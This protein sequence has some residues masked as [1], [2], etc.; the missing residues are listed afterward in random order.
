[1]HWAALAALPSLTSLIGWRL[2]H[3]PKTAEAAVGAAAPACSNLQHLGLQGDAHLPWAA[4]T[5][6]TGLTSL[7][8]TSLGAPDPGAET[9]TSSCSSHGLPLPQLQE[10]SLCNPLQ[11]EIGTRL[12]ALTSLHTRGFKRGGVDPEDA[13]PLLQQLRELHIGTDLPPSLLPCLESCTNLSACLMAPEAGD[14]PDTTGRVAGGMAGPAM[15][16]AFSTMP[17][18]LVRLQLGQKNLP[19]EVVAALSRATYIKGGQLAPP[20]DGSTVGLDAAPPH[21]QQLCWCLSDLKGS[22]FLKLPCLSKVCASCCWLLGS[23]WCM[24]LPQWQ[25][26]VRISM[27]CMN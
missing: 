19:W 21:L 9:A 7:S 12:T 14:N 6:L 24:L 1:M 26:R 8:C 20:A 27:H 25:T 23:G 3:A 16:Q 11:L 4:V 2:R 18:G 13:L 10:L 5:Q 15:V 22:T 17:Y